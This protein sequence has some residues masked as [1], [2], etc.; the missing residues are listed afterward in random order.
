MYLQ[1]VDSLT[2]HNFVQLHRYKQ[3]IIKDFIYAA[4][5]LN[6]ISESYDFLLYFIKSSVI[7][8]FDALGKKL[9]G[10]FPS[11]PNTEARS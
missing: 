9:L 2:S 1:S 11:K 8:Y 6:V 7:S 3:S 5:G 4:I 10:L